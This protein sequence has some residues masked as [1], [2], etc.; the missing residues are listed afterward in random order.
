MSLPRRSPA[1]HIA[2]PRI[3]ANSADDALSKSTLT[4]CRGV[5]SPRG[6]TESAAAVSDEI[7]RPVIGSSV[8]IR[9]GIAASVSGGEK[10]LAGNAVKAG[11]AF[12]QDT[13]PAASAAIVGG[14]GLTASHVRNEA[15]ARLIARRSCNSDR[16]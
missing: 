3:V 15:A 10:E 5:I 11:T 6:L 1:N 12:R 14:V 9:G 16:G 13:S 7:R 4:I 2:S 8:A